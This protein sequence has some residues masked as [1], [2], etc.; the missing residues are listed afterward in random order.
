[1]APG[2]KLQS[3]SQFVGVIALPRELERGV[4]SNIQPQK[5]IRI[6]CTFTSHQTF[7]TLLAAKSIT[8]RVGAT[9]GKK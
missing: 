5:Y 9:D 3:V 4:F 8:L 1:M 7:T 2:Q 6:I